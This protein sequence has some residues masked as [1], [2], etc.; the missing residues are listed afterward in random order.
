MFSKIYTVSSQYSLVSG[1]ILHLVYVLHTSS[2][3]AAAGDGPTAMKVVSDP[4]S[5]TLVRLYYLKSRWGRNSS[6]Q[7]LYLHLSSGE[8]LTSRSV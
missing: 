2:K 5:S 1:D 4:S 8:V 3:R 6:S 7:P